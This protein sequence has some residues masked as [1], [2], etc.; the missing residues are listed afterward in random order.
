[1]FICDAEMNRIPAFLDA[2]VES[3]TLTTEMSPSMAGHG[4]DDAE[5]VSVERDGPK[6]VASES[7]VTP[8]F[9]LAAET[10]VNC[11]CAPDVPMKSDKKANRKTLRIVKITPLCSYDVSI[12]VSLPR[13]AKPIC[14]GGACSARTLSGRWMPRRPRVGRPMS[15]QRP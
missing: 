1:M 11:C 8:T 12:A 4:G 14:D 10:T 6:T 5:T 9:G 7:A 3:L 13:V 15:R 2:P